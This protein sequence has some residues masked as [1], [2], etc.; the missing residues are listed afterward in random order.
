M[1]SVKMHKYVLGWTLLMG[2][3]AITLPIGMMRVSQNKKFATQP[4]KSFT[5]EGKAATNTNISFFDCHQI[6]ANPK[7]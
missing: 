6:K 5:C 3:F 7:P 2:A 4:V 1:E